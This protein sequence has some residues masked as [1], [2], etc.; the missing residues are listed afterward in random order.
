MYPVTASTFDMS[1]ELPVVFEKLDGDFVTLGVPLEN[2]A[3]KQ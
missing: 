1:A 2:L 3:L